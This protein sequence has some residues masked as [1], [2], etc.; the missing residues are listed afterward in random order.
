MHEQCVLDIN[1]EQLVWQGRPA[2]RC[3]IF[4]HWG[5]ILFWLAVFV[6]ACVWQW[7]GW[8]LYLDRGQVLWALIPLPLLVLAFC[9]SAGSVLRA[10][11]EWEHVF[12]VL[13]AEKLRI[14]CDIPRRIICF[15][16]DEL[17]YVRLDLYRGCRQGG[18][19]NNAFVCENHNQS[20]LGKIYLEFGNRKVVLSCVEQAEELFRLLRRHVGHVG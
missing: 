17:S 16:L 1:V 19:K 3:F 11:L 18:K 14:Q 8:E 13:S 2:P 12:Y 6:F 5:R 20:G 15:N 7:A 4:R 10:R 9:L